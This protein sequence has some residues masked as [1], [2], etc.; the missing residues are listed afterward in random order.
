MGQYNGSIF[1]YKLFDISE[2]IHVCLIGNSELDVYT[3]T[4]Y[5][6]IGQSCMYP[7]LRQNK[8]HGKLY[9]KCIRFKFRKKIQLKHH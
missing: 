6:L 2:A 7:I 5:K 1:K 9:Q 4:L 8:V 3:N